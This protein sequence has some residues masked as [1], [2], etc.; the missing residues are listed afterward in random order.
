I[1]VGHAS[2]RIVLVE[3]RLTHAAIGNVIGQDAFYV[4]LRYHGGLYRF[5]PEA[6]DPQRT[7]DTAVSQMLL[8]AAV[9]E[10]SERHEPSPLLE[11]TITNTAA[12]LRELGVAKRSIDL[13]SSATETKPPSLTE[14]TNRL[15]IAIADP[16][17]LGDLVLAPEVPIAANQFRIEL[18]SSRA[19]G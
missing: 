14:L 8:V 3:G 2:G 7:L 19:E 16:Y 10:D 4:L 17:L 18:W 12:S 11:S 15:G 13:R 1:S 9:R 5:E 6:F